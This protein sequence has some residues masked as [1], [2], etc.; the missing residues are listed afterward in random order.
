MDVRD[1]FVRVAGLISEPVR[2][3]MLWSLL[4]G[5]AYTATELA[6]AADVSLT[7]ASNHLSRMLEGGLLKVESQGRHRYYRFASDEVAHVV[8]SMASL[9]NASSKASTDTTNSRSEIQFCRSCYDHLAGYVGVQI[10]GAMISK[11]LLKDQGNRFDVTRKGWLWAAQMGIDQ[12]ELLTVRRPV[13]RKC[14]DWSERK[15]HVAGSLGA[16]LMTRMLENGWL[17]RVKLSRAIVV[18]SKGELGLNETFGLRLR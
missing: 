9:V 15:H 2:A 16:R 3:S 12:D 10:T 8:E 13:T 6:I 18:T 7:S 11:G 1:E 17:R 5:K 14:L 4:D